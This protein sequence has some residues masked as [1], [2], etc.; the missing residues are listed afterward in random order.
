MQR[1]RNSMSSNTRSGA[2]A[3]GSATQGSQSKGFQQGQQN[4]RRGGNRGRFRLQ[5]QPQQQQPKKFTGKE[6]DLGDKF[7]Y[8][9]TD[10]WEATDQYART[11]EEIVRYTSAFSH[12]KAS[13]G[14]IEAVLSLEHPLCSICGTGYD[15]VVNQNAMVPFPDQPS[16]TCREW[17]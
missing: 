6:E 13:C 4:T 14:C 11:T 2:S 8:Q 3:G 9:Y 12:V 16:V 1:V 10:G 17:Q 7:V 5:H 15:E